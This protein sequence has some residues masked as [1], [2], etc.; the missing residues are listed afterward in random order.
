[1]RIILEVTSGPMDGH[2]F[3]FNHTVDIGREGKLKLALDRFISR[4]H[5]QIEVKEPHVVLEDL[6]STNGTFVDDQRLQ[7]RVELRNGQ[8]FRVGRTW[9]E[10]NWT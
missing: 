10:I 8:V 9:L 5:A 2:L 6:R 1:M 4:R 3:E 7:G